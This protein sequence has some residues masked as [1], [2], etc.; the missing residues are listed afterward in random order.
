MR[1]LSLIP[2]LLACALPATA[3]ETVAL[4]GGAI[5]ALDKHGLHLRAADGAERARIALRGRHLHYREGVAL[6]VDANTERA[7]TVAVDAAAG[8]LS[9]SAVL[10]GAAVAPKLPVST[11]TPRTCYTHSSPARMARRSNGCFTA[12]HSCCASSPCRPTV[13]NAWCTMPV[14]AWW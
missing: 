4:P 2:F 3:A 7:M 12:A 14:P 9:T 13:S 6:V 1:R 10:D 8:T 5:L 11:A